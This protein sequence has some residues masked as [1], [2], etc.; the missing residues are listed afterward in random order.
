MSNNRFF[1]IVLVLVNDN[2]SDLHTSDNQIIRDVF[3]DMFLAKTSPNSP[4]ISG[5]MHIQPRQGDQDFILR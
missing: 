4:V 1:F 3:L 5:I 2:N